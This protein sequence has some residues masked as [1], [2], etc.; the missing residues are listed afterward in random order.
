MVH[1]RHPFE[2]GGLRRE[3]AFDNCVMTTS[4]R[5]VAVEVIHGMHNDTY[6]AR[7]SQ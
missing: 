3:R 6:C 1:E 2:A 7:V 5:N 4:Y